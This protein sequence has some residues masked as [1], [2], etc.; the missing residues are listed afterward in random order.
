MLQDD[1]TELHSNLIR[2]FLKLAMPQEMV[3]A[4]SMQTGLNQ[5]EGKVPQSILDIAKSEIEQEM[6]SFDFVS[7]MQPFYKSTFSIDE[8]QELIVIAESPIFQKYLA[9]QP[10]LLKNATPQITEWSNG[11]MERVA[12]KLSHLNDVSTD[13]LL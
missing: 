2:K 12:E 4:M 3:D 13:T 11:L 5:L 9:V 1:H 10:E 8:I 6:K 7:L